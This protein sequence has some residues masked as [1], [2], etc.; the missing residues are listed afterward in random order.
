MPD[1]HVDA[2]GSN[3]A[4]Y[5]TWAKA[6]TTL[7]TALGAEAAGDRILIGSAY[8]QT[9][10]GLTVSMAGSLT[11]PVQVLSGTK[12]ATSGLT[13]LGAGAVIAS[14]SALTVNGSGY[15]YG[16]SWQ[17]TAAGSSVM[18]FGAA[19]GETQVYDDCEF[20]VA[21]AGGSTWVNL[22][23]NVSGSGVVGKTT[24]RNCRMRL[25]AAAQFISPQ[26]DVFIQGL[27]WLAGG[28]APTRLFETYAS[29]RTLNLVV[30]GAD[31]TNIGTAS[32][33]YGDIT[34]GARVLFRDVLLPSGWTGAPIADANLAT[35]ARVELWNYR[36]G[37]SSWNRFWIRDAQCTL[38]A[39]TVIVR[40]GGAD[41]EN[42][43][44]SVRMVTTP[45]CAWPMAE[46]RTMDFRVPNATTG[47]N[48]TLTAQIIRDSVAALN[49][50]EVWLEVEEPDGTVTRDSMTNVL[51]TPA[52]QTASSHTWVTTGMSNPNRQ[53]LEVTINP[54]RPGVL[55]C[56]VVCV[57]PSA[58]IYV[59]PKIA[60]T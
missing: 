45:N 48:I 29:N 49:D 21:G 60:K 2:A 44:Y 56:R 8:T 11:S 52:A 16:V 27:T 46:A 51:S 40:T 42:G 6:A 57:L 32:N 1:L 31:L 12:G 30:E 35:G 41:D 26:G 3:T 9:T 59:C 28:V 5:D 54:S 34:T 58:T 33:L 14:S 4:P 43:F 18:T 19:A 37:A 53:Q 47:S 38:T 10:A 13:A 23:V 20:I 22:G 39:E 15:V 7:A 24:L 17:N 36:V 25:G 55:L 50:N